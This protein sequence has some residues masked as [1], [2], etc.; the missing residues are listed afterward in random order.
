M[1]TGIS[2]LGGEFLVNSTTAEEQSAPTITGLS[3]G[4]YVIVWQSDF[5]DEDDYGVY[6]Q[7]Y[8]KSGNKVGTEFHV[9]SATNSYQSDPSVTAMADGGYLV[10]WQSDGQDTSG[11]GIFAQRYD[12]AGVKSGVEF[13][14]NTF[15][16]GAQELPSITALDDGSFVVV[17]QSAT[18]DVNGVS[19]YGQHYTS[20]GVADGTEFHINSYVT[21]D[22]ENPIVTAL[23]DGGFVVVWTSNGQDTGGLGI[24]GQRY[25]SAGVASGLEFQINFT[26]SSD[27]ENPSVS[28]LTGGGFVVTWTSNGQDG[29]GAGVYGQQY[30]ASGAEVGS[31]FLVNSHITASQS[32]STV[33][34]LADGGYIVVWQSNIQDTNSYGVYGQRYDANGDTVGDET[35]INTYIISEQ[36]NPTVT[37]LKNGGFVVAWESDQD[38][39]Y[40]GIYAQQFEAKLFGTSDAD[41]IT[42]NIGANYLN[43]QDGNDTLKGKGGKDNI[44]GGAGADTLLGGAQ[45]DKLYG[46]AGNDDLAGGSGSD[47]LKGNNGKDTLNGGTGQDY[48]FG[49][50]G[51]DTFVFSKAFHSANSKSAD[52][53]KDFETGSDTVDLSGVFDGDLT[54]I[55]TAIFTGGAG[56]LRA[57]TKGNDTWLRVDIDG[58]G[59][60]D[61]KVV[62]E[63]VS[64]MTVDDFIL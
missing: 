29:S 16:T 27:Q 1:V 30:D 54:F 11:S 9:S 61:M 60:S 28:G 41:T 46:G 38:G 26:V 32:D 3:D 53:I 48:L 40:L 31:E 49:G 59:A 20:V 23:A 21:S 44:F 36:R 47:T 19:I 34:G 17:W 63:N 50:S 10:V 8:D 25:T 58:D 42:D 64:G 2:T 22:Q 18:Q 43:G 7:Q 56:E 35:L 51:N 62:L 24:Y 39:G 4:G 12:A 33:S 55:G 37:V 6:G 14:I 13:Q 45:R 57:V 15:T 5:Q 52:I